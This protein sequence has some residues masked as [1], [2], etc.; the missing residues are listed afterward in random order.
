M[1]RVLGSVY[2]IPCQNRQRL[3]DQG[4]AAGGTG[5]RSVELL[6]LQGQKP[7]SIL[8]GGALVD[9]GLQVPGQWLVAFLISTKGGRLAPGEC[10][11]CLGVL[12]RK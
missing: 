10:L 2:K 12:Y 3:E 1:S 9:L 5:G 4:C 7:E 6:A 11:S 8:R